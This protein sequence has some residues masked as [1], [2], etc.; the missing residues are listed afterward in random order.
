MKNI[1]SKNIKLI[2]I[3]SKSLNLNF[4]FGFK[5]IFRD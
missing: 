1:I 2:S 5:K 4:T 3:G